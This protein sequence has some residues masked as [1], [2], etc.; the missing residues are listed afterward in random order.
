[1]ERLKNGA[2]VAFIAQ[3]TVSPSPNYV[4]PDARLVSRFALS[5]DI[6]EERFSV[7]KISDHPEQKARGFTSQRACAEAWCLRKSRHHRVAAFPPTSRSTCSSILRA[8]DPQDQLG[9]I[10]EPG[11]NL[12]RLIEIFGRPAAANR[13]RWLEN[14]GPYRLDDL[15][16]QS[17]GD[18]G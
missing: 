9:I 8:E 13:P 11:I 12:T 2:S 4:L 14:S 15:K 10:G 6:W 16:N 1:M 7:T 17:Q 5:Y 3:L 18:G